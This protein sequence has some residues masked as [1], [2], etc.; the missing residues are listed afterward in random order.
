MS[1]ATSLLPH[2]HTNVRVRE[3]TNLPFIAQLDD[4]EPRVKPRVEQRLSAKGLL[5]PCARRDKMMLTKVE[6]PNEFGNKVFTFGGQYAI[7]VPSHYQVL[8]IIG[9]G[10][11]GIVC[12]ALNTETGEP[13]AI[14]KV[15][16]LF[17]DPVDSKRVLR[18]ILLLSFLSHPNVLSLKDIFEPPNPDNFS[19]LYIIT[20]LMNTD[21]QTLLRLSKKRLTAGHCQYFSLQLLCALQYLHSANIV[22]RDLKPSNLLTDADCNLR[23]CDFGLARGVTDS[24]IMTQYVVTRWYRAP[25]LLLACGAYDSSV[26]LWGA[27]CLVVEMV[28][29]KPLLAGKDYIHQINLIIDLLGSPNVLQDLPSSISEEALEYLQSLPPSRSKSLEEICPDLRRRFEEHSFFDSFD[30]G[31][32][33]MAAIPEEYYAMF[34]DFVMGMLQYNPKARRSAKESVAHPWLAEVRGEQLEVDGCVSE[35]VFSWEYDDAELS[36]VQ[37]REIFLEKIRSL[38]TAR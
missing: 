11:Y 18:E 29:G 31:E 26:D 5:E 38:R 16:R 19:D 10:A 36:T 13:V 32:V 21:M 35:A 33:H 17:E 6:G 22:H 3:E 12:S 23:L 7:E 9:R 28:T 30:D 2:S 8:D 27:G 14:K 4:T 20:E 15:S 25:E 1:L 24:K 34:V 37:L